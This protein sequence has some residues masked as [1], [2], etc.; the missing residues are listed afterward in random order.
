MQS[1]RK[2][3]RL[4]RVT[5]AVGALEQNLPVIDFSRRHFD[6][7]A[8]RRAVRK[9]TATLVTA[10]AAS[11]GAFVLLGYLLR[12]HFS[13]RPEFGLLVQD[14]PLRFVAGRPVSTPS[15]VSGPRSTV[16]VVDDGP[17][18]AD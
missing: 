9:L 6:Q 8:D 3:L 15:P 7:T 4:L 12:D 11:C 5:R 13:P 10:L 14:L 16:V 18:S 2:C 17:S 1:E